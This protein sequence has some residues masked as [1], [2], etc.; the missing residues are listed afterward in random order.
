MGGIAPHS[1]SIRAGATC[2]WRIPERRIRSGSGH[3]RSSSISHTETAPNHPTSTRSDTFHPHRSLLYPLS[4]RCSLS[5]YLFRS[6]DQE[7]RPHSLM[8]SNVDPHNDQ[9][10][11]VL[12][13]LWCLAAAILIGMAL[14]ELFYFWTTGRW[15]RSFRFPAWYT[16]LVGAGM[17]AVAIRVRS[18]PVGCGV[19]LFVL[20]LVS[21]Y[22]KPTAEWSRAAWAA[23][24]TTQIISGGLFALP[25]GLSVH[26][27]R[28]LPFYSPSLS[29]NSDRLLS[30]TW[31]S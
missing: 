27:L 2:Q 29:C 12:P 10:R 15:L 14:G 4:T 28:S 9:L 8:S 25:V 16:L 23:G 30:I 18:A 17:A 31:T 7:V 22:W 5:Q 20:L 13:R 24:Q 11:V 19:V 1:S 3:G 26:V 6:L 21:S